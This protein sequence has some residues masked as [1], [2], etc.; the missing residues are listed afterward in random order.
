NHPTDFVSMRGNTGDL[1]EQGGKWTGKGGTAKSTVDDSDERDANLDGREK[2]VRIVCQLHRDHG[3]GI[4]IIG[5]FLKSWLASRN[6][7]KLGHR[8][9]AIEQ[10]QKEDD[11]QL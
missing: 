4:A 1:R 8:E 3:T 5:A 11:C 2:P 6:D 7:G 10:D 9:Q